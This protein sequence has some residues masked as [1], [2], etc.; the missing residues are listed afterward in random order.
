M[1]RRSLLA[2]GRL[3]IA[4]A[5]M[6]GCGMAMRKVQR[7]EMIA[8]E[9]VPRSFPQPSQ[10]VAVATFE[11]M[12]TELASAE[13]ARDSEFFPAKRIFRADGSKPRE[14]ELPPNVPA[15]WL[16]WRSNG[17]TNRELMTLGACHYTGKTRQGQTVTVEILHEAD[18]TLVKVHIDNS[19]D[20]TVSK[21]LLDKVADRL[22]HPA[23]QPGSPEEA[24][25]FKAFFG[26][27]ES[28]EALPTI[29]KKAEATS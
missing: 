7:E 29:R 8:F 12:R 11:A 2:V 3:M 26:G 20:R 6:P 21:M 27:V 19:T 17:K 22:T 24:A 13:F 1:T 5:T 25:M 23:H 16:E 9:S 28:R 18:G 14:G 10:R 4:L 15:F